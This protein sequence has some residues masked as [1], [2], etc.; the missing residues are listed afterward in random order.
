MIQGTRCHLFQNRQG[1]KPF[2]E[3]GNFDQIRLPPRSSLSLRTNRV[4]GSTAAGTREY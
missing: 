3:S 2:T 1:A 4:S